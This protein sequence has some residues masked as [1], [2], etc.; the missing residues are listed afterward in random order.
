MIIFIVIKM[1]IFPS[2]RVQEFKMAMQ[3][4]NCRLV[5]QGTSQRKKEKLDIGESELVA[6]SRTKR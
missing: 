2:F 4:L 5:W 6:K 1:F 3:G